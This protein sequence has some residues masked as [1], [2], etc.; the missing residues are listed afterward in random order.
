MEIPRDTAKFNNAGNAYQGKDRHSDAAGRKL[1]TYDVA[2]GN[3]LRF[4]D[5]DIFGC[6]IDRRMYPAH[7]L[8][9]LC[10]SLLLLGG[11]IKDGRRLDKNQSQAHLMVISASV[12]HVNF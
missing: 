7:I 4:R 6:V 10:K 3:L 9:I 12:N 8:M 1:S 2:G 11:C 5:N